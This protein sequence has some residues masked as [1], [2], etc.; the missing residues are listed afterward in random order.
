VPTLLS[1]RRGFLAVV[2]ALVC[3]FLVSVALRAPWR[4]HLAQGDQWVTALALRWVRAWHRD[5]AWASRFA[6]IESPPTAEFGS[7]S[8]TGPGTRPTG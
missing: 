8:W 4:G 6:L 7:S 5:G 1:G 3:I 2:A